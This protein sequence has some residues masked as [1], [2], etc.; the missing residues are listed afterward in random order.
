MATLANREGDGIKIVRNRL[1]PNYGVNG[2]RDQVAGG[3]VVP[4]ADES[5]S[6]FRMTD[7]TSGLEC[8]VAIQP[9]G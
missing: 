8:S 3:A 7:K 1:G 4:Q 6:V 9:S 2:G 5:N